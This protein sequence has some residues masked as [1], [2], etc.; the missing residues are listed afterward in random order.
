MSNKQVVEKEVTWELLLDQVE[1][2]PNEIADFLDRCH[3]LELNDDRETILEK[4][5]QVEIEHVWKPSG[6][7]QVLGRCHGKQAFIDQLEKQYEEVAHAFG[8]DVNVVRATH[9]TERRKLLEGQWFD[10]EHDIDGQ[11]VSEFYSGQSTPSR[12]PLTGFDERYFRG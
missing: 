10:F 11:P 5:K 9:A 12:S 6:N 4:P 1:E 2:E 7:I 3:V 8:I